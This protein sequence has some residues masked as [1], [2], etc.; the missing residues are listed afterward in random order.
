MPNIK[1]MAKTDWINNVELTGVKQYPQSKQVFVSVVDDETDDNIYGKSRPYYYTYD[2][3]AYNKLMDQFNSVW[4]GL[5][6]AREV[7]TG[8]A[9]TYQTELT[10]TR[11]LLG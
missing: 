2:K 9:S 11:N 6:T 4:S 8:Y 1:D 5:K 7:I 3:T 10:K